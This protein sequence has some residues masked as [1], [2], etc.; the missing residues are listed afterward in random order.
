MALTSPIS[1]AVVGVGEIAKTQHI[2]SIENNPAF[3]LGAAVS[4]GATVDG[5]DNFKSL[6]QLFADRPDVPVVALCVPP[7]VRFDMAWQALHAGKHVLLEKPPGATL[8]EVEILKDLAD[9]KGLTLLATWHSRHAPAVESARQWLLDADI[10]RIA[11]DWREDVKRWHP[12]QTWIWRAGGMGVFDP[13]INALSMLT[14]IVP[15]SFYLQ[16]AEMDF[17]SNCET[18]IG[19][20][21][22][23]TDHKNTD[24]SAVFD[25][26]HE[27]EQTWN[28]LV[29]TSKG[30]LLLTGGGTGMQIDGVVK[31][32]EPEAEYASIY[33]HFSELLLAGKSDVDVRPLRHVADA[34]MIGKRN[35]VEAFVE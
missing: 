10:K 32:E 11:I 31:I 3:K 35:T 13:G 6:D 22:Q 2:P 28:V 5:V 15:Q 29:E 25:W 17:P 27:G 30:T 7:Q 9:E 24:I 18:P 12:G 1:I 4:R 14:H 16:K 23:F 8:S 19:A 26:R 21:L 34:F 33:Q 20:Q